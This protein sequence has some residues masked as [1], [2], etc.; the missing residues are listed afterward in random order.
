MGSEMCIR[1][2]CL[3]GLR[4]DIDALKQNV[5]LLSSR[6]N[7]GEVASNDHRTVEPFKSAKRAVSISEQ[8]SAVLRGDLSRK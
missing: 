8:V 6:L 2:R 4:V 7:D 5:D 3:H 1:D